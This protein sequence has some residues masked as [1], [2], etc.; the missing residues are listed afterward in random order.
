MEF[1][2]AGHLKPEK[3]KPAEV[4]ISQDSRKISEISS[5]RK[6]H[7]YVYDP[8]KKMPDYV[9]ESD[10]ILS[11]LSDRIVLGEL[12]LLPIFRI[13]AEHNNR[14]AG[15][16]RMDVRW[17][18]IKDSPTSLFEFKIEKSTFIA[19]ASQ[20]KAKLFIETG[21][22]RRGRI[23]ITSDMAKEF[24]EEYASS[25]TMATLNRLKA[26]YNIPRKKIKLYI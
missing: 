17:N 6:K 20:G 16:Q 10:E 13:H 24:K 22:Q 3:I 8:E 15:F 7:L 19:P 2:I 23:I 9:V 4:S 14:L 11:E 5:G 1:K 26:K 21:N 12:S 25:P 18:G